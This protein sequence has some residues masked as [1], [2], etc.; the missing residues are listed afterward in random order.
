MVREAQAMEDRDLAVVVVAE[1]VV[2]ATVAAA[3]T[4]QEEAEDPLATLP[5]T[6]DL[7][8]VHK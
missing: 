6:A 5:V 8:P 3:A 2:E 7:V 4:L 1:A